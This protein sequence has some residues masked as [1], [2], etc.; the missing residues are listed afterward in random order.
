MLF[1]AKEELVQSQEEGKQTLGEGFLG[2]AAREASLGALDP[3]QPHPW[4]RAQTTSNINRWYLPAGAIPLPSMGHS[5]HHPEG[6]LLW[7][8]GTW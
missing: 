3:W 1:E 7:D 5:F 4:L 2:I 6:Q 8:M